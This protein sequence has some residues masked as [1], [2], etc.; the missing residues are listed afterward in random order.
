MLADILKRSEAFV[1]ENSSA[2]LT[3]IGVTGTVTTAYLTGRASFKAAE[4][5]RD[6]EM[7]LEN[8]NGHE[9]TSMDFKE[10]AKTVWPLYIPPVGSGVTTIAAIIMANRI[11]SKKA[12][13]MAAAYGI[14][15]QAFREYR[16]KVV[17]KLGSTKATQVRDEVAQDK[18]NRHPVNTREVILAGT[19][20]VLFFDAL[21]G[22]Y[23]QSTMEDVKAAQNKVN[24]EVFHHMYASLTSFYE[25]VGLP[26][27]AFSDD[28][29]FNT[30]YICEVQFSSTISSDN[31]PCI[32]VGFAVG[33]TENYKQLF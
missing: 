4:M 5:I 29:G 33:P 10:R 18:V 21:T 1:G 23:F 12:A 26:G 16:D 14:S 17:E 20:E 11:E 27:T 31:R 15:E 9:K 22:R 2:I 19:G 32:V 13:A 3:A 8:D 28:V 7:H 25:H 24:E 6:T 30:D